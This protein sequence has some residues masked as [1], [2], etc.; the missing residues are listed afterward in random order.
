MFRIPFGECYHKAIPW[1]CVTVDRG[2]M[3]RGRYKNTDELGYSVRLADIPYT[4]YA[5]LN[6]MG[7]DITVQMK[8][9]DG[10]DTTYRMISFNNGMYDSR[11]KRNI[12]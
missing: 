8:G 7:I 6:I 3:N 9:I 4:G 1:Y 10:Y 12:L 11:Y 2:T 5:M